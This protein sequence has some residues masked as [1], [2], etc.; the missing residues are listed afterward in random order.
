MTIYSGAFNFNGSRPD[1]GD[2]DEG[3]LIAN[4]NGTLNFII[5]ID[6]HG[7]VTA[8][9]SGTLSISISTDAID[10]QDAGEIDGFADS[11]KV[12]SVVSGSL[13]GGVDI[14]WN[15]GNG[16][17]EF[18]GALNASNVLTGSLSVTDSGEDSIVSLSF[19]LTMAGSGLSAAEEGFLQDVKSYI[20]AEGTGLSLSGLAQEIARATK[21]RGINAGGLLNLLHSSEFKALGELG[22]KLGKVSLAVDVSTDLINNDTEGLLADVLTYGSKQALDKIADVSIA[23]GARLIKFSP[24]LI[25]TGIGAEAAAGGGAVLVVLGLVGKGALIVA[26]PALN[27]FIKNIWKAQLDPFF[28]TAPVD[29]NGNPIALAQAADPDEID[30]T[31]PQ[32]YV[33]QTFDPGYYLSQHPDAVA[34]VASGVFASAYGYYLNVGV[35]RGDLPAPGSTP[36]QPSNISD[37]A[38]LAAGLNGLAA[39]NTGIFELALGSMPTDGLSSIEQTVGSVVFAGHGGADATLAAL[40]NRFAIDLARNQHL[41]GTSQ[42]FDSDLVPG[43]LSYG[44][45]LTELQTVGAPGFGSFSYYVLSTTPDETLAQIEG[46][47]RDDLLRAN[48]AVTSATAFGIAEFG[49]VWVGIVANANAGTQVHAAPSEAAGGAAINFL[50]TLGD[51]VISLGAH[52]GIAYGGP[53]NDR[54]IGADHFP[55]FPAVASIIKPATT[56]NASFA[57]AINLNNSFGQGSDPNITNS[58]TTPHATVKATASGNFEYYSFS[59]GA[60]G[61]KATFDI[62]ATSGF[63]SFIVLDDA[64]NHQLASD[65][66]GAI[67]PGSTTGL[68]SFLNYTFTQA[69]TYY[70]LVE[71]LGGTAIPN[72]QTY[73]LNVSIDGEHVPAAQM[74]SAATLIGGSGSDTFAF[75]NTA[76][77]NARAATPVIDHVNDYDQGN[78]GLYNAAEG[79]QIDLSA[80]LSTAYNHGSGQ[81]VSSLVRGV[82]F[83]TTTNLQIDP[84]GAANGANWITIA[85]LDGVHHGNSVNVIL[86][87]SQPAGTSIVVVGNADDFNSNG[88]SDIL[89]HRDDATVAVWDNGQIG[90]AHW[91]ANP[92]VVAASWHIS[93]TGDFDGN[94]H[95]DVLWRNDDGSVSIWDNGAIGSAHIVSGPGVVANSWHIAG[96][97][98]FDGNGQSDIL[99][100]NDNGA[101]SIWD[102]GDINQAHIIANAGIIPSGWSIAGTGDFDGNGKSD[103][104]WNRADGTVSIWDNGAI[105]SAHIIANPGVVPAGWHIAG[106]GDFDGNGHD[107]ILWHNDNGAVSIWDNGAIGSAHIIANAGVVPNGWR[108]ANTGDY[109]GNGHA[110]I[111]WQNDNGAVSIWDNGQIASAH[112]I[113][114]AGAVPSGWHIV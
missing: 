80:L 5:G 46:I 28:H 88:K 25:E 26:D 103:I 13:Q 45:S 102:N 72:G 4:V 51:D 38:S 64:A 96:T 101:A 52:T 92:G 14:V 67:D 71:R 2:G 18:T 98:D 15:F 12:T 49:G 23:G 43:T 57:S 55:I 56:V 100:R 114:N 39:I 31:V 30:V 109:D 27:T 8:D 3:D 74:E 82:A 85:K 104:L 73:T 90:G 111:L 32:N 78:T 7:A 41:S 110:D 112:I 113:A 84:D 106:T 33:L 34:A 95:N 19:P 22:E 20:D 89:W 11:A 9:S 108:I 10:E 53:G 93:G 24:A 81:P 50:G 69:G 40:A 1:F 91:I 54:L 97:G 66:D 61:A 63:N 75:G 83:G 58:T 68:D 86:D 105:G 65:D 37:L 59:V 17:A 79:D 47:L 62:D 35:N 70:L 107:D 16:R 36:I 44:G 76:L 21:T 99:W 48:P 94:G 87:A 42:N 29:D 6:A 60:A 77:I